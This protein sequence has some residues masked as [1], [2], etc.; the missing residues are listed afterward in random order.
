MK[1]HSGKTLALIF[2]ALGVFLFILSI[3]SPA[4][5]MSTPL[6]FR[7]LGCSSTTINYGWD[8]TNHLPN[9][10][11]SDIY[12]NGTDALVVGDIL[13]DVT[14]AIETNLGPNTVYKR[15]VKA[16]R[17]DGYYASDSGITD[18]STSWQTACTL[19]IDPPYADDYIVIA[20]ALY[21]APNSKYAECRLLY[22]D[23]VEINYAN[24]SKVTNVFHPFI[25]SEVL[26][27][28]GVSSY[29]Y[30]LQ[31]RGTNAE[32]T[33]AAIVALRCLNST[34]IYADNA[35]QA[36]TN[37]TSWQ[38]HTVT[39]SFGGAGNTFLVTHSSD[40]W[41]TGG[42]PR[43][44]FNF[45]GSAVSQSE[46][47]Q[48][49]SSNR[50]NHGGLWTLKDV[51]VGT[52]SHLFASNSASYTA[53]K[54]NTHVAAM[55]LDEPTWNGYA[56][57]SFSGTVSTGI[58]EATVVSKD[59]STSDS[60]YCLH[61]ASCQVK[62]SGPTGGAYVWW[63][64]NGVK[65]LETYIT[66]QNDWC[67]F[68]GMSNKCHGGSLTELPGGDHTLSLKI[69]SDDP[70]YTAYASNA[71]I[72]VIPQS[73]GSG[74]LIYT[75]KS[76][77]ISVCTLAE[78]PGSFGG[79]PV[80]NSVNLSWDNGYL[81]AAPGNPAYTTY[82]LEFDSDLDNSWGTGPVEIYSGTDL[83]YPHSGLQ[84]D[85]TYYY[86]IKARN[87]PGIDTEWVY[88]SAKTDYS[89]TYYWRGT[90]GTSW[91]NPD[92]WS[93]IP[94]GT[95][96][97][98][99]LIGSNVVIEA[100]VNM[101]VMPGTPDITLHN[102]VINSGNSCTGQ[103]S[104]GICT[105]SGQISGG[106]SFTGG[107]GTLK[108]LKVGTGS[109]APIVLGFDMFNDPA[110][111]V[112][113]EGFGDQEI[114]A[115]C[116]DNFQRYYNLNLGGSGA[117]RF[118]SNRI[119]VI[120]QMI[121]N[122]VTCSID[123][124]SQQ[125]LVNQARY[126]LE[127]AVELIGS[128][129]LTGAGSLLLYGNCNIGSSASI[130]GLN[131]L[132]L[133]ATNTGATTEDVHLNIASGAS[134]NLTKLQITQF[135]V[136]KNP[137]NVFVNGPGTM[138]I[139]TECKMHS[140]NGSLTF[141][142][143]TDITCNDFILGRLSTAYVATITL[144][145]E[146][147]YT[148]TV[149][150]NIIDNGSVILDNGSDLLV[151][152]SCTI[153]DTINIAHS[154]SSVNVNGEFD[155]GTLTMS[156]GYLYIADNDPSFTPGGAFTGGT[157]VLD[158][159][160]QSI[161]GAIYNNLTFAGTGTKSLTANTTVDGTTYI[162]GSA[163][164]TP[165]SYTLLAGTAFNM[166]GGKFLADTV[167][168]KLKS[169]SGSF[170]ST[171][172][173]GE[174]DITSLVI[175]GIGSTGLNVTAATFTNFDNITWQNGNPSGTYLSLGSSTG[176]TFTDTEW[177]NHSID[178]NCT[179]NIK[180]LFSG[181]SKQV[182]MANYSGAGA[183]ESNDSDSSSF[184]VEI[185]W[186][187]PF[188]APQNF[189]GS[190]YN[191][192]S[193]E[194]QWEE[195]QGEEGYQILDN[196]TGAV[197]VDDIA[198]NS[199]YTIE[200]GLPPNTSFHRKVRAFKDGK[201]V[202]S[203]NSSTASVYTLTGQ[204][205]GLSNTSR[206]AYSL[207]WSCDPPP[208][209]YVDSTA[210]NF[211]K[212]FPS[213]PPSVTSG[214]I[215]TNTWTTPSTLTP[216]TTYGF[217][218][219]WRN[220]DGTYDS[221]SPT[222][223]A[224]TLVRVPVMENALET[225]VYRD[226]SMIGVKV[227]Q[228]G[229]PNGTPIELLYAAGTPTQPTGSFTSA[230]IQNSSY[231]FNVTGLNSN[232]SYWFKARAWN[233][234]GEWS[235]NCAITVWSTGSL[236]ELPKS[237]HLIVRQPSN[238]G[239][240]T[241]LYGI[242][243]G[244]GVPAVI[245]KAGDNECNLENEARWLVARA[246]PSAEEFFVG[247]VE[248]NTP[249]NN[250]DLRLFFNNS[251]NSTL[252]GPEILNLESN[253]QSFDIAYEDYSGDVLIVYCHNQ[254]ASIY[255]KWFK[256]AGGLSPIQILTWDAP[257]VPHQTSAERIC[258]MKLVPK[259]RSDDIALVYSTTY[260]DLYVMMWNGSHFTTDT[261]IRKELETALVGNDVRP[262]DAC[263]EDR[264]DQDLVVAYACAPTID[265]IWGQAYDSKTGWTAEFADNSGIYYPDYVTMACKPGSD[266]IVVA[267]FHDDGDALNDDNVIACKWNGSDDFTNLAL[268]DSTCEYMAIPSEPV[269]VAWFEN[270]VDLT[271]DVMICYNDNSCDYRIDWY[272]SLNDGLTWAART[273]FSTGISSAQNEDDFL[274][275]YT[276][277]NGDV[278]LLMQD[279][280]SSADITFMKFN[281]ASWMNIMGSGQFLETNART[282]LGRQ[283]GMATAN[284]KLPVGPEL[285]TP[286][287]FQA[288][289]RTGDSITW[290]WTDTNSNPNEDGYDIFDDT[291]TGAIYFHAVF[292]D[293]TTARETGLAENTQYS[294]TVRTYW[295]VGGKYYTPTSNIAQ[296]YTLTGPPTGF[297][298][299]ARDASSITLECDLP[300]NAWAGQTM[301]N[302]EFLSGGP[303]GTSSGWQTSNTWTDYDLSPDVTY[304]YR[305]IWRNGDGIEDAPSPP[306]YNYMG[307]SF[308]L[309]HCTVSGGSSTFPYD[310]MA[311]AFNGVNQI[312]DRIAEVNSGSS[313]GSD[314]DLASSM[315]G[316]TVIIDGGTYAGQSF[317]IDGFTSDADHSITIQNDSGEE[318]IID[319]GGDTVISIQDG[320][321]SII[322]IKVTGNTGS[323]YSD[324]GFRIYYPDADN[325]TIENCSSYANYNGFSCYYWTDGAQP[326]DKLE[327]LSIINCEIHSNTDRGI[328]VWGDVANMDIYNCSIYSNGDEGIEVYGYWN[329]LFSQSGEP[330]GIF[331]RKNKIYSNTE[332]GIYLH[333]D[334]TP[335]KVHNVQI[336]ENNHIY[337]NGL[338][339]IWVAEG[340]DVQE[341]ATVIRNNIIYT[342]DLSQDNGI[343]LEQDCDYVQ[344]VNNT[345]YG[346]RHGIVQDGASANHWCNNNIISIPSGTSYYGIFCESIGSLAGTDY[347]N[348]Y[349]LP[350]GSGNGRV[351]YYSGGNRT[352]LAEWRSAT[353]AGW[354]DNS[355]EYN[356]AFVDAL[357]GDFHLNSSH[358][359]YDDSVEGFV[360]GLS[361]SDC[362]E[363]GN[364]AD[365]YSNEPTPNGTRIN[366]GAYGNTPYASKYAGYLVV[367]NLLYCEG[368]NAT[369]ATLT[370]YDSTPEF[371][372]VNKNMEATATHYQVQVSL[373]NS[374]W[375]VWDSG[376][377][378]MSSTA[379]HVRCPDIE[380]GGGALL[381]STQYYWRI[382][383]YYGAGD[384]TGSPWGYGRY[385]TGDEFGHYRIY[386]NP[387]G[388]NNWPHSHPSDACSSLN[389]VSN[390]ISA[391]NGD[392]NNNL[393][394]PVA[395]SYNLV[396]NTN[397]FT[398]I[399]AGGTYSSQYIQISSIFGGGNTSA[400]YNITVQNA[401]GETPVVDSNGITEVVTIY[402]DY[403]T[404]TGIVATGAT[405]TYDAGFYPGADNVTIQYCIA[406]NCYYG[407]ES[408]RYT[409]GVDPFDGITVQHC[410][411]DNNSSYGILF[412][413][414]FTNL[415]I[416][417]CSVYGNPTGIRVAG[418]YHT[419][420]FKKGEPDG[421]T[422]RKNEIY[423]NTDY[424]ILLDSYSPSYKVRDVHIK[425]NNRIYNNDICGIYVAEGCDVIGE[426]VI[427]KNNVIYNTSSQDY[428]IYCE[429]DSD[430]IRIINNTLYGNYY[431][432]YQD[433]VSA[434]HW[435][436]N[437]IICIPNSSSN[438]GIYCESIGCF[439]GTDYNNFFRLGSG[440]GRVGYYNGDNRSTFAEWR[441]GTPVGWDDNSQE[442]DPDFVNA[443]GQDFH[444]KSIAG[445][446][447]E[448]ILDWTADATTSPCI[449]KG[450]PGDDYSN[451][452]ENNGDRINQGA[453]G[454]T[455]YASKT[456]VLEPLP[457][458]GLLVEGADPAVTNLVVYDNS[459][460]FS[461]IVRHTNASE[462]A[463]H[464][465]VEVSPNINLSSPVWDTGKF[466]LDNTT[467]LT[468]GNRCEDIEYGESGSPTPLSVNTTYYW[469]IKFFFGA[470]DA[471]GSDWT[472]RSFTTGDEMNH[473]RVYAKP[474]GTGDW[475]YS[476]P[477]DALAGLTDLK[478]S[479]QAINGDNNSNPQGTGT[480][481]GDLT[482]TECKFTILL[483][484]G[485]FTDYRIYL[486]GSF[487]ASADYHFTVDRRN[488]STIAE[489][490]STDVNLTRVRVY[491]PYTNV[492]NIM[493]TGGTDDPGFY[494][495]ASHTYFD[496]CT[497][498]GNQRGFYFLAP[499]DN[500]LTNCTLINC[501]ANA[502]T[503]DGIYF[504]TAG[505]G[506]TDGR[507][508]NS[509]IINCVSSY[510]NTRGI[511]VKG[512]PGVAGWGYDVEN[513]EIDNCFVFSNLEHGIELNPPLS[514]EGLFINLVV[515]NN[516]IYSNKQNGIYLDSF[517][518]DS[519]PAHGPVIIDNN[520]I[521]NN[522][523]EGES[524]AGINI[525]AINEFTYFGSLA[526]R[527]NVIYC[528]DNSQAFG[529]WRSTSSL[530]DVYLQII[531]NTIDN[532][533]YGIRVSTNKTVA[534]LN[535][536]IIGVQDNPNARG[537]SANTGTITYCDYSNI[538]KRG[539]GRIGSYGTSCP[540]FYTWKKTTGFDSHSITADPKFVN[541]SGSPEARD[542]H[543]K[544]EAGH[545]NST[546]ESWFNDATTSPSIDLGDPSADYSSEPSPNGARINQGAY[547]GTIYASKTPS[548]LPPQITFLCAWDAPARDVQYDNA[549]S[550]YEDESIHFEFGN[551]HDCDMFVYYWGTSASGSPD[552]FIGY[553]PAVPGGSVAVPTTGVENTY[554]F[555]VV[556]E[557]SA[558]QGDTACYVYV[559]R[560]VTPTNFR[561]TGCSSTTL[562]WAWNEVVYEDGFDI[563][564]NDTDTVVVSDI[565][566]DSLN[567]IETGLNPNTTY[568]RYVKAYYG[569][570]LAY[571]YN[572][573]L[574]E[575]SATITTFWDACTLSM[576]GAPA[577]KYII[578]ATLQ[579]ANTGTS[580]QR[581]QYRLLLNGV[582]EIGLAEVTT[583]SYFHSFMAS[584]VLDHDGVGTPEYKLQARSI[585]NGY[586]TRVQNA[587][588][589]AIE[590]PTQNFHS[591]DNLTEESSGSPDW[592][593]HS[594]VTITPPGSSD[595][596]WI[597][598]SSNYTHSINSLNG[599]SRLIMDNSAGMEELT[600]ASAEPYS[601]I[602]KLPN[603]GFSAL[604]GLSSG[605][606]IV[607]QFKPYNSGYTCY[608]RNVHIAAIRLNDSVWNG[609]TCSA[610]YDEQQTILTSG[611]TALEK[612]FTVS[613]AQNY[614]IM[615][616]AA[617]GINSP[618]YDPSIWWEHAGSMTYDQM[619]YG[620]VQ[621]FNDRMTFAAIRRLNLS[622]GPHTVRIIYRTSSSS[623]NARVRCP[624]IVAI[625]LEG[626]AKNYNA[627]SNA[628]ET[629]TA[630][631]VPFMDNTSGTFTGRTNSS[632]TAQ[633]G[634]NG[635]PADTGI[636]LWYAI[637]DENGN[638]AALTKWNGTLTS[639]YSWDVSGLTANTSYWFQARAENWSGCFTDF[640]NMT[641]WSTLPGTPVL[642]CIDCTSDSLT[643]QW[644][645]SGGDGFTIFD[646]D[647]DLPITS[648]IPGGVTGTIE[649]GL[650]P[651]ATYRRYIR[652]HLS[653]PLMYYYA[654]N[655]SEVST[656]SDTVW[657]NVCTLDMTQPNVGNYLVIATMQ[658][659]SPNIDNI[660]GAY[661][662][663]RDETNV[664]NHSFDE[665]DGYYLSF[666][667]T[668]VLSATGSD[669]YKYQLQIISET[670]TYETG[671]YNAA[672]IA[673][674][675]P[676]ANY[677]YLDNNT[678]GS[679]SGSAFENHS[680][681]TVSPVSAG[682]DYWVVH[683]A[684]FR[685][686]PNLAGWSASRLLNVGA[687]S[688]LTYAYRDPESDIN[689][690]FTD[691]G[692]SVLK[693]ISSDVTLVSQFAS[694]ASYSCAK[695]NAH[696]VTVRLNDS[697]WNGYADNAL[698]IELPATTTTVTAATKT[699]T[700]TTPQY[701][702]L[703]GS[704]GLGM[705]TTTSPS[706]WPT[707]WL[708]HNCAS[709]TTTLG[710]IEFRERQAITARAA[711]ASI[712][713]LYLAA[714]D[715][716][717]RLKF[718]RS[719]S[720]TARA[721][722][723]AVIAIPLEGSVLEYT[724]KSNVVETCTAAAPPFMDN[725]SGTFT[726]RTNSS[727]T[728]Q[729]GSNSN[730]AG[731]PIEL[732][733]A[734]GDENGNT[735]ALTQWDV[736]QTSGYSWDVT[737]LD[738]NTSY[739]FQSRAENW[740]G[741][742]TDFCNMTVWSTLPGTPVLAC[743]DCTSDS[744]TWQ[745][746]DSGGT[747][748]TI[749]DNDT[750]IPVTS[751][752]P[753][754]VTGTIETGLEPNTTYTRYIKAYLT[755]PMD[756]YYADCQS[757]VQSTSDA[758]WTNACVL[759]DTF[760]AGT[761]L[762]IATALSRA[763]FS[764]TSTSFWAKCRLYKDETDEIHYATGRLN[765]HWRSFMSS[766]VF[767]ADGVN[768]NSFALQIKGGDGSWPTEMQNAAIVAIK[769]DSLEYDFNENNT[770]GSTTLGSPVLHSTYTRL[771]G[772]IYS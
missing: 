75:G 666:M 501:F 641:V 183:G 181:P 224:C 507:I 143:G 89:G 58:T 243:Q 137:I 170:T 30:K 676:T 538:F 595:D 575:Q 71:T 377:T 742:F 164:F 218:A 297:R 365:D 301:V 581:A 257:E 360:L 511:H 105:A 330:D 96:G 618:S 649:T 526:V 760:T 456:F 72:I 757:A 594:E 466:A 317:T 402:A 367:P 56:C 45:L 236:L 771:Y 568:A 409:D 642:S 762:V 298:I 319:S 248:N 753:S 553:D 108:L 361:L 46:R 211:T 712:R 81:T 370:V 420:M 146:G 449:D 486:D 362:I 126:N 171:V 600:Y 20:T 710:E 215:T 384:F 770:E 566:P 471:V 669:S 182:R 427:I 219:R 729:V 63:E 572:E 288:V 639:G 578:M 736:D 746:T 351:G 132:N 313:G 508:I 525:D 589:I 412:W 176:L 364:P 327:N 707:A 724:N 59:F 188:G 608:E 694:H 325:V 295:H 232:T 237:R 504:V 326:H 682:D 554:Y 634:L 529:I 62:Y 455:L 238:I 390:Q 23:S 661:R 245:Y 83:S 389:Q 323:S 136:Q 349:R 306:L 418:M 31:I 79:T 286:T 227:D 87:L 98:G 309:L 133:L 761:Y 544:S 324:A 335:Y 693:G 670:A 516:R 406:N 772:S 160:T 69:K 379:K 415:D 564:D 433:G 204:A 162:T 705:D 359:Q 490:N 260:N 472:C 90:G 276:D 586:S 425:D 464:S 253:Y 114:W 584:E 293:T 677:D 34:C 601:S 341:N 117:K 475:P 744:L 532:C 48:A 613:A 283:A 612:T 655:L 256:R 439:S 191:S 210:V 756:Y 731:T 580:G 159:G 715:H 747:G 374:S 150:N 165:V 134:V 767:S 702:L 457:P 688:E 587:A 111:T 190:G 200:T 128:S 650:D 144:E 435:C 109:S 579:G 403:T 423:S 316:S 713:R 692:F 54:K 103:P 289:A 569:T 764:T 17:L 467:G 576:S 476:H 628:V 454:N 436:N 44:S 413:G 421:V 348:F 685:S 19:T 125:I 604:A 110:G 267:G 484:N 541:E 280:T 482:A 303:E 723:P 33:N 549:F 750:D 672:I 458:Q 52:A 74:G 428:G 80:A 633:A 513:F 214:A 5:S 647:T 414:G 3:P 719:A 479:I 37:S 450:D 583:R 84:P 648:E 531:N 699:F 664:I 268:I 441:S 29:N 234:S 617:I 246:H 15:Y 474:S 65:Y 498:S 368:G 523:V 701:Y 440:N 738:A 240:N 651:N 551:A 371:S 540:D 759:E 768:Q 198:V 679:M 700:V 339:G 264:G 749:Y 714:G 514:Q 122:G 452:Q 627:P 631:A 624:A 599:Y 332:H 149:N 592:A 751:E 1:V 652:A 512:D 345:L 665:T 101:P 527:N 304:V 593:N 487:T 14:S 346:H 26:S 571:Y 561:C 225:F 252:I 13:Q 305:V 82:H 560:K 73:G 196:S 168:A 697:T 745:W 739:W 397:K 43:S 354:D 67:T 607:D 483:D 22:N 78:K 228:N 244:T 496:N 174:F 24:Y 16:K 294:R 763:T 357:G 302:F 695:N 522:G 755:A 727:I 262:F 708:E 270:S 343:F 545:W 28:D 563:F 590:L 70:S 334:S 104:P 674:S 320:Y 530:D 141:H 668:E 671:A 667:S 620:D 139:S 119:K 274:S 275:V 193:I 632:I 88:T 255:Y 207:T 709:A 615:V 517:A 432:I 622:A 142:V 201:T 380:Y 718:K 588:I 603:C 166:S 223:Y 235:A 342:T 691:G 534:L 546:T 720:Y 311:K 606:K 447:N 21:K 147:A 555:R 373:N 470:A 241:H 663:V 382:M 86:R 337:N 11:G 355:E 242:W 138:D 25:G 733:Y 178:A 392:N 385:A 533:Y 299:M 153:L 57:A 321:V 711:F 148:I 42:S 307:R 383:F 197:M 565:P 401:S 725:T 102:I 547:G 212:T 107:S 461:G 169:A 393:S 556:A 68:A 6:N 39:P 7:I 269:A 416:Y 40:F 469:R 698:S 259:P 404:V 582:T 184:G 36:Q 352:T 515:H 662:L 431:G 462:V 653:S 296:A 115:D 643:W 430:Y 497:S 350:N 387:V 27:T 437:N 769:L 230:S 410:Q 60:M 194:W 629:C 375:T 598:H 167:G 407:I 492:R 446:W 468:D 741:C 656:T 135:G 557:K 644:T 213:G 100:A 399:L 251:S 92:N 605:C 53:Y 696:I 123:N 277:S 239:N 645:D 619:T 505:T 494:S 77:I 395:S 488:S 687:D 12:D 130:N 376:R 445:H 542:Y 636:E 279:E 154:G 396:T 216:N 400:I 333:S 681:L 660:I 249:S 113:Y 308:H 465:E 189:S 356:P 429:T 424:G 163:V 646:N 161:P 329:F 754:G 735:S 250:A 680:V 550:F 152:G 386:Y 443:A 558:M 64:L 192:V 417:N 567:T 49:G 489:I 752:I 121:L 220:G 683:S 637:G 322:G 180:C 118:N 221:S 287:G 609:Y 539:E 758:S 247:H 730:P 614:L 510:N 518:N 206:T 254:S 217:N 205:T 477:D 61:M 506:A 493:A 173:G 448:S 263:F 363:G 481:T 233:W 408:R 658:V 398:L 369:T 318:V 706:W 229:N 372:A 50:F 740:S 209:A 41:G 186:P 285:N 158:G 728:V 422:I 638:T 127:P 630:A 338:A 172:T 129:L 543:L 659:K 675:L 381:T 281:G 480:S 9:E 597:V 503:F 737:A 157:V 278:F 272:V 261:S 328:M 55:L 95:V 106:G 602:L 266:N 156:N 10:S 502:S 686:S 94:G 625:P 611:Q 485:T 519:T 47:S 722:N 222:V 411:L 175:D 331:I 258:W 155:I 684:N 202:F 570:P 124:V 535:N 726:G 284:I 282:N 732:W 203:D 573:S 509:S 340:C 208:N 32:L 748:F 151:S 366:M 499:D 521:F 140:N 596:Y 419:L 704:C 120:R 2:P 616:S 344:I 177:E 678:L 591:I 673:L 145:D 66:E 347:N 577:G 528:T 76:N 717:I 85:T 353:P 765:S 536:N 721:R 626:D 657:E 438:Y 391:L 524:Y 444:L 336:I 459:P 38:T 292:E 116:T 388:G 716:T 426:P 734:I 585:T 97:T 574:T 112:S 199:A 451:E 271:Y 8:D 99:A 766:L 195:V 394:F 378:A 290:G 185:L 231:F 4:W 310:T 91:T 315:R 434:N 35:S 405:D 300:P 265:G 460:E 537:I 314:Y 273:D 610:R 548:I 291:G 473:H 18:G 520:S 442:T 621:D 495:N 654:E 51:S 703:M 131:S 93:P 226:Q 690:T 640:C 312:P 552:T 562:T 358:G 559:H 689:E 743:I 463:T 623:G 500:S 453:Y 478:N 187:L 491:V 635:N 179:Y